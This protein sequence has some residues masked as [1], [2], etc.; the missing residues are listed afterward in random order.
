MGCIGLRKLLFG[1]KPPPENNNQPANTVVANGAAAN[2]PAQEDTVNVVD[3]SP[4]K[5][6]LTRG[7]SLWDQ[8]YKQLDQGLVN[9]YEKLLAE[10]RERIGE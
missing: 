2:Q 8:A 5:E 6:K 7:E 9:E 1:K 3:D 10:Q 4:G